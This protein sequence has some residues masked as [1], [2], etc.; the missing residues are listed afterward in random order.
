MRRRDFIAGLVLA[1]SCALTAQAQQTE[2]MRRIGVL[3]AHPDSDPE[4]QDYVSAFRDGLR[5]LGW[6]EGQNIRLDFRW[7]A[8]DDAEVR[9]RSAKELI[10]LQPDLIV[11]Q[12]HTADGGHAAA[13][14]R[15]S[16]H[17]RHRGRSGR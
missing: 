2:R 11:T 13:D 15:H 8:L 1:G 3:M 7:G 9:Q 6:I 4:F 10:A 16:C 5:K 12:K 14:A 17:F